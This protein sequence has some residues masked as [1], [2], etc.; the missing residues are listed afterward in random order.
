MP[1]AVVPIPK[2][3]SRSQKKRP[4]RS[5]PPGQVDQEQPYYNFRVRGGKET[6]S[7]GNYT[8]NPRLYGDIVVGT[9]NPAGSGAGGKRFV[10][11]GGIR[12][13]LPLTAQFKL[14]TVPAVTVPDASNRATSIWRYVQATLKGETIYCWLL[15]SWTTPKGSGHNF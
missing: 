13:F 5:T 14:T 15:Q 6:T 11:S 10:G 2:C 4:V 8:H 1:R 3:C 7:L 12:A 9:W